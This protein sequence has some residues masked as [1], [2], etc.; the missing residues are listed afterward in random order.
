MSASSELKRDPGQHEQPASRRAVLVAGAASVVGAMASALGRPQAAEANDGDPFF[1]GLANAASSSTRVNV[2]TA[3]TDTLWASASGASSRAVRGTASAASG[4]GVFGE[5]PGYGVRGTGTG[6]SGIGVS[7]DSSSYIGVYGV[8]ATEGVYGWGTAIGTFGVSPSG[9]GVFGRV[10]KPGGPGVLGRSDGDGTGVYGF[11]AGDFQTTLP[12]SQGLT[13]VYGYEG[14]AGVGVWG[15]AGGS[16][17]PGIGVKGESNSPD[18]VG[19][20]GT[21]NNGGTGLKGDGRVGVFASSTTDG[22]MGIWGRHFGAG[23]G[24]AGDSV[25]LIGVSGTSDATNQPAIRGRSQGNSTGVYGFSGSAAST[26]PAARAKTGVFGQATQDS[27]SRGVFGISTMGN[28]VRGEA[29]TG[30]A[31]VGVANYPQG[32]AI[33]SSGRV[34]FNKVSGI[35]TLAAGTTTKTITPGTDV[36]TDSFVLLT[37]MVDLGG[38]RLW[39]TK[40]TT[41]N[42]VTI[43]ISSS[44]TSSLSIA[45]LLLS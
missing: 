20:S 21:G 18:G 1:L 37:P 3:S 23:Y 9:T 16:T 15:A 38:R 19:V 25:S 44:S 32:Y 40:D 6:G 2:T 14:G 26:L 35:A 29:T 27:S 17:G 43:R 4:T 33:Q 7:G 39:F 8:G 28:G 12:P 22:W 45:W 5:S 36:T 31:L 30:S 41:A 11:S 34:R 10:D 13:G 42:T 24:V